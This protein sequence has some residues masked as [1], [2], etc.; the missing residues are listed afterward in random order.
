MGL[1]KVQQEVDEWAKQFK[2]PYWT[3][4]QI[5]ARLAEETGELAREV[6]DRFGPKKKKPEEDTHDIG[7]E[8]ADVIMTLCCLA[9]SRGINLDEH[10]RELMK[11]L[12]ERDSLR[13]EK[14]EGG[15]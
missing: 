11:K 9:N 5:I 3:P 4:H 8:I 13:F 15:K 14:R 12:Y 6:N 1:Y 10:W 7:S 2:I